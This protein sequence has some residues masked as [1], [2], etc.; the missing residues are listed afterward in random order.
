MKM[1]GIT[2]S[3]TPKTDNLAL[4][5]TTALKQPSDDAARAMLARGRS[6]TYRERD[7]PPG[8][9]ILEHPD[10]TKGIVTIDLVERC[11]RRRET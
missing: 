4:Q 3:A 11:A 1:R 7:T 9:V 8:R 6:V 2:G 5:L 10:G